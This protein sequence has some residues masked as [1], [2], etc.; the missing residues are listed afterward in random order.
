MSWEIPLGEIGRRLLLPAGTGDLHRGLITMFQAWF[1]N[2]VES[3]P[4]F[5]TA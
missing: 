2:K 5:G 4:F 3:V 1:N